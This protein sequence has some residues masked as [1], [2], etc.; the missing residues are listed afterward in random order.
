[1]MGGDG[2]PAWRREWTGVGAVIRRVVLSQRT[3]RFRR[4]SGD[5]VCMMHFLSSLF[6]YLYP[7]RRA[8]MLTVEGTYL[9]RYLEWDR[10]RVDGASFCS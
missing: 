6:I 3:S 10:D 1:M 8:D 2:M 7:G 9:S 5:D 4:Y